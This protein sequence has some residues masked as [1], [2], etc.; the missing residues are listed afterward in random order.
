MKETKP[1]L[2]LSLFLPKGTLSFEYGRIVFSNKGIHFV[3]SFK[4]PCEA[5]RCERRSSNIQKRARRNTLITHP[6]NPYRTIE[7]KS[8]PKPNLPLFSI[9]WSGPLAC[10]SN[11]MP[12][13]FFT[14][15]LP[16]IFL[17]TS[18]SLLLLAVIFGP[19]HTP[20]NFLQG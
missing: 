2:F 13:N 6:N 14:C 4:S 11:W 7:R 1:V 18:S 10:C 20:P 16:L 9:T 3:E 8:N 5:I 15:S 19:I 17:L 12:T